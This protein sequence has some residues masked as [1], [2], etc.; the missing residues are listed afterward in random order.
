MHFTC[1]K[2]LFSVCLLSDYHLNPF[3]CGFCKKRSLINGDEIFQFTHLKC[4]KQ[5]IQPHTCKVA[6][7][8]VKVTLS[9]KDFKFWPNKFS[10]SNSQQSFW[11]GVEIS[12]KIWILAHFC[13]VAQCKNCVKIQI[14][15]EISNP[16]QK[17]CCK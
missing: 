16:G 4:C 3:Y 6:L 5:E 7:C 8:L 14:S 9:W 10:S 11:P 17:L 12:F 2:L 15:K 1:C 13:R